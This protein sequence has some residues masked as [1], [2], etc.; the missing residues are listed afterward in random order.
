[1][2]DIWNPLNMPDQAVY[3]PDR[4]LEITELEPQEFKLGSP[5]TLLHIRGTG[6]V[7]GRTLINFAGHTERT[8]FVSSEE[9]T[10]IINSEVWKGPDDIEVY[11]YDAGGRSNSMTFMIVE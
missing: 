3:D 4:V 2:G 1:M 7:Q 9:L 8:T 5:D 10:T 6:F 11:V